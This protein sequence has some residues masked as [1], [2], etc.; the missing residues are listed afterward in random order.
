MRHAVLS[1]VRLIAVCLVATL[2]TPAQTFEIETEAN[3][4]G[5]AAIAEL[6][7]LSTADIDQFLPIIEDFIA[8]NPQVAVDYVV[9]TSTEVMKGAIEDDTGFDLVISSAMDLQTKLT[10]DGYGQ[11]Y[12]SPATARVPGWGKWRDT[13]YAFTQEPA[14]ILISPAAF[15]GLPVPH[16][17]QEL[18]D[19][20][21]DNAERFDGRVGTYDIRHSGLG[22]LFATQDSRTSETFWRLSE[23]MG[24]LNARLYCCSARMIADIHS[25]RLAVAYNVLSSYVPQDDPSVQVIL[26]QDYTTVMLRS[27]IILREA[28]NPQLARAFLDHLLRAAWSEAAFPFPTGPA[29]DE[30][31]EALRPIRLGPGLLVYLDRLKR[32]RFLQEWQDAVVQ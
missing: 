21:R 6:R 22:Y 5:P 11:P 19:V 27:A 15:E 17:R 26:P 2:A 30:P 14:A 7:I 12:I 23:V 18:I 10:N 8:D 1:H 16:T 9:A 31:A 28:P 25:G 32:A 3:F 13:V 20:L 29:V 24:S 4:A